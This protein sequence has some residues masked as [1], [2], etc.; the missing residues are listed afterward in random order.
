M[1]IVTILDSLFQILNNFLGDGDTT[2]PT[3]DAQMLQVVYSILRKF[4]FHL[5]IILLV[6]LFSK[7]HLK[8]GMLTPIKFLVYLAFRVPETSILIKSHFISPVLI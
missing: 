3:I 6:P 5:F 1:I 8:S 2:L 4:F 7:E